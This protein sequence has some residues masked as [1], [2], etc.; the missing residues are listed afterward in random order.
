MEDC[1]MTSYED[2]SVTGGQNNIETEPL[3]TDKV[4]HLAI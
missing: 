1:N 2:D 4:L 3:N